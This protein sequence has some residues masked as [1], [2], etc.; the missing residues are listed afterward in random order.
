M[1]LRVMMLVNADYDDRQFQTSFTSNFYVTHWDPSYKYLSANG[2]T[3]YLAW[4]NARTVSN[5]FYTSHMVCD[6]FDTLMQDLNKVLFCVILFH[7][8]SKINVKDL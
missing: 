6:Y 5:F 2:I 1:I 4:R 8:V 7:F 3:R